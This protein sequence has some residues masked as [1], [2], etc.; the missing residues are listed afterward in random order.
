MK[1]NSKGVQDIDQREEWGAEITQ[2]K[3]QILSIDVD[4]ET[5]DS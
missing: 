4:W 3:C 2:Q 1:T 5:H